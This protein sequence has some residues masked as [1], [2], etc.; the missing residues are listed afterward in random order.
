MEREGQKPILIGAKGAM[1]KK[2]GTEARKDLEEI[3]GRKFYLELFVKVKPKWRE[4]ESFL[5]ELGWQ[6]TSEVK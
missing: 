6:N 1:I 4:N 5:N 2:I 3:L